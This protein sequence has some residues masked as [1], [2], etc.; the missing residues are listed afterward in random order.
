MAEA[1]AAGTE[2]LQLRRT[3]IVCLQHTCPQHP[4]LD[5]PDLGRHADQNARLRLA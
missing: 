2:R 1:M 5:R 3:V 4:V